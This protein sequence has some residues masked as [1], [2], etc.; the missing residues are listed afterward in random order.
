MYFW[1]KKAIY[2]VIEEFVCPAL[3]G[4]EEESEISVFPK[5]PHYTQHDIFVTSTFL[6][7]YR[8]LSLCNTEKNSKVACR[9]DLE[10]PSG[11]KHHPGL[12][13]KFAFEIR[14]MIPSQKCSDI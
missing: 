5:W 2:E 7:S 14:R 9:A 6:H 4:S 13:E 3:I 12:A 11:Q 1:T 10:V 8:I